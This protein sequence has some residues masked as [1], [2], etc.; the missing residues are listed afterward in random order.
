MVDATAREQCLHSHF[1]LF[2][3]LSVG[4]NDA[5]DTIPFPFPH[6]SAQQPIGGVFAVRCTASNVMRVLYVQ[7]STTAAASGREQSIQWTEIH[8]G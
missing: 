3:I 2:F 8:F 5:E 1:P 6:R 7:Q 4:S